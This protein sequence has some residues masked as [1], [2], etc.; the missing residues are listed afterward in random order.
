MTNKPVMWCVEI[1]PN[2][3]PLPSLSSVHRHKSLSN[4]STTLRGTEELSKGIRDLSAGMAKAAEGLGRELE[5]LQS[6]RSTRNSSA[7]P[8]RSQR[9]EVLPDEDRRQTATST[10]RLRQESGWMRLD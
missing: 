10:D 3:P 8:S 9:D 5:K 4:R 1:K 2:L 6:T 7:G